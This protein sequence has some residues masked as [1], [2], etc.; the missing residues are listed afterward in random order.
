M[1]HTESYVK[2]PLLIRTLFQLKSTQAPS[3]SALS[4]PG[5]AFG[6]CATGAIENSW[7]YGLMFAG[8]AL[9][10]FTDGSEMSSRMEAAVYCAQAEIRR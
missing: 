2:T 3:T 4:A 9:N 8:K 7:K 10:V 1:Q 5:L 6:K